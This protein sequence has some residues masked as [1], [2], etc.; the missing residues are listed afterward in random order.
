MN[1][2]ECGRKALLVK[3]P[4][5]HYDGIRVQDVY[6]RNTEVELCPHC[7]SETLVIR[8]IKKVHLM[9][10]M[11]IALQPA[12]LSGNEVR[13]LRKDTRM[14]VAE[15]ASRIGIAAE[16]FSRWENGRS[17]AQQ[18]E[19]LARIDFLISVSKDPSIDFVL[20]DSIVEVLT[21]EL[22]YK[23]DFALVVDAENLDARPEYANVSS[24]EFATPTFSYIE[25]LMLSPGNLAE[26]RLFGGGKML[27][28]NQ[29]E[30]VCN[31]EKHDVRNSFAFAA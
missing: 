20:P 22:N 10:G 15:W 18:V 31:G 4:I 17:P 3:K 26:V 29:T 16:T 1:C 8:N 24:P 5:V 6:M 30:L 28:A 7:G 9:I 25:A 21:A 19:K 14:N 12:K 23:R 27:A 2:I 13:F 11:G